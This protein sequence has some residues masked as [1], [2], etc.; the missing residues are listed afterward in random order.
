VHSNYVPL[1]RMST[2]A[3]CLQMQASTRVPNG[4]KVRCLVQ[5]LIVFRPVMPLVRLAAPA[6]VMLAACARSDVGGMDS[7]P[8]VDTTAAGPLGSDSAPAVTDTAW[9]PLTL[10]VE[11]GGF[12]LAADGTL[13][14]RGRPLAPA[15]PMRSAN[16]T[17]AIISYHVSPP[18]RS[19]RWALAQGRS[20]TFARVFI[21]DVERLTTRETP[22]TKYGIIP[23]VAWAPLLP[24]AVVSNHLE[25][26]ALLYRIELAT[27]DARQIDFGRVVR[28]PLS[29]TPIESTLRWLDSGSAFSIAARVACNEAVERCAGGSVAETRRFRV[30]L[31]TLQVTDDRT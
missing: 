18:R 4:R 13:S 2:T 3:P 7:T 10:G 26:T 5:D 19:G 9:T 24:Y 31:H 21:L 16:G 6:L 25:G 28:S 29:A 15:L 11:A 30:D 23:W 27:G 17:S 22:A 20:P 14:W 12:A 1:A 8:L